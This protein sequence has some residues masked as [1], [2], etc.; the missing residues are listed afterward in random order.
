QLASRYDSK[1]SFYIEATTRETI[2]RLP[3]SADDR[4]LDLGCGTGALLHR[5]SAI[6]PI[7]QLVG[8]EP[9]PEMRALARRKLL[10]AI[11]LYEGWAE[12]LPFAD[13]Q[14]DI[15]VSCNMF[16]YI[17]QPLDALAEIQRVLR[18]R[19]RLVITDWCGDYLACRLFERYQRL[20]GRAHARIYRVHDCLRLV[21]QAGYKAVEIDTY[22]LNWLWG[23]MTVQC[24]LASA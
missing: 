3:L 15:V 10:P 12:R 14:F 6:H 22:K 17:E 21:E 19:G 7:N 8:V 9:V 23:I 20:L 24:N 5:L 13:A 18:P 4:L 11:E 1:W 2:A 16:H